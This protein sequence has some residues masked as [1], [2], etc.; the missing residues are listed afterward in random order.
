MKIQGVV[1]SVVLLLWI[2]KCLSIAQE[3]QR[4]I[5]FSIYKREKKLCRDVT[6]VTDDVTKIYHTMAMNTPPSSFKS[7]FF[8][9][10]LFPPLLSHFVPFI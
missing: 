3:N 9:L 1:I 7:S 5:I 8:S 6:S 10:P 4:Y 2:P